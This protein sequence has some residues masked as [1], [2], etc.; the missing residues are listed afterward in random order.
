MDKKIMFGE[1]ETWGQKVPEFLEQ[2]EKLN[3]DPT[4]T[5]ALVN[6]PMLDLPTTE[7]DKLRRMQTKLDSEKE[8]KQNLQ[9]I[10]DDPVQ[11]VQ[12]HLDKYNPDPTPFT[13]QTEQNYEYLKNNINKAR[14]MGVLPGPKEQNKNKYQMKHLKKTNTWDLMLDVRKSPEETKEMKRILNREFYKRGPKYMSEK[15]LKLIGQHPSQ[16][17][18]IVVEEIKKPKVEVPQ[19]PVEVTIKKRAD[20]RYQK[21][22]EEYE[23]RYGR[24]G[25]AVF[26]R[27]L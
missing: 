6:T 16:K 5:D 9:Q 27:P 25:L 3:N 17:K 19:E 24:G 23:K 11:Y 21:E 20:A 1:P 14:A 22:L 2:Q 8:L 18:P 12:D 10:K 26:F 13:K 15:E 7:Y 4:L